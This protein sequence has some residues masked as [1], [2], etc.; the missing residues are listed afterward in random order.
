MPTEQEKTLLELSASG[1]LSNAQLRAL[2]G[3]KAATN[4]VY[5]PTNPF[6]ACTRQQLGY[7]IWTADNSKLFNWLSPALIPD[8]RAL[9]F[10]VMDWRNQ[11]EQAPT[12]STDWCPVPAYSAQPIKGCKIDY[13]FDPNRFYHTGRQT[14]T[15][16]DLQ[17]VCFQQPVFNL[18][19]VQ[20]T[21]QEDYEQFMMFQ[22]Q[23]TIANRSIL[24]DD[25]D[26]AGEEDGL[27]AWFENFATRHPE[28]TSTCLTELSPVT[29]DLTGVACQDI[30]NAIY[31]RLWE[32]MDKTENLVG[33]PSIPENYI[34]LVMNKYDAECVMRCQSCVRVCNSPI[35]ISAELMTP[36]SRATFY[37]DY[38]DRLKGG[39][40]GDG[41]FE[42]RDGTKI[43]IIR[44]K[45]LPRGAFYLL[46]KGWTGP[47]PNINAMRLAVNNWSRWSATQRVSDGVE[48]RPLAGGALLHIITNSGI[49]K[50]DHLRWNWRFF[51]NAPWMQTQFTNLAPC[52][53]V[54]DTTWAALPS[55]DGDVP[56]EQV[57]AP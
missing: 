48:I 21:D 14:L 53:E 52:T 50:V 3:Q 27:A 10:F 40:F 42:L 32:L 36:A 4:N 45:S 39:A 34:V 46:V 41:Y 5:G 47:Q 54:V 9:N 23:M 33:E 43:S 19:G 49:C 35:V 51:S 7:G 17:N 12:T 24:L 16:E 1:L 25:S 38:N 55:L 13:C 57:P 29:V 2:M 56:C 20:I 37:A 26:D 28:L 30:A 8:A 22:R 6:D 18:A 44:Q 11:L 31:N 15:P